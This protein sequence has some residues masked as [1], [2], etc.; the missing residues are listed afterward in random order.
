MQALLYSVQVRVHYSTVRTRLLD[1][2]D[3]NKYEL[4]PKCFFFKYSVDSWDRRTFCKMCHPS[5]GVFSLLHE[6]LDYYIIEISTARMP[7]S[8]QII[9]QTFVTTALHHVWRLQMSPNIRTNNFSEQRLLLFIIS[10]SGSLLPLL[11]SWF[12]LALMM[13]IQKTKLRKM[14]DDCSPGGLTSAKLLCKMRPPRWRAWRPIRVSEV[15]TL[16]ATSSSQLLCQLS[17]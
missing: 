1:Q 6:T 16:R 13:T 8:L 14:M 17:V 12:N 15:V 5:S 11:F 2:S 3:L 10:W 4:S 9:N 7:Q